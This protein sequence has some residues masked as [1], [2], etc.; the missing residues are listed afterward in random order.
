MSLRVVKNFLFP[1]PDNKSLISK[2]LGQILP[3][4]EFASARTGPTGLADRADRLNLYD[5]VGPTIIKNKK[6]YISLSHTAH[7]L[8]LTVTLSPSLP[9]ELSLPPK[10]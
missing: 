2:K 6:Q 3:K 8:S 4:L 7:S 5:L 10:P 9:H 1:F